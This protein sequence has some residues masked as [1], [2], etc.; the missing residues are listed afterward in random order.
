MEAD[1][2][3]PAAPYI[4]FGNGQLAF[5]I[6]NI[7]LLY[8]LWRNPFCKAGQISK[9]QHKPE[10]CKVMNILGINFDDLI[11]TAGNADKDMVVA[12]LN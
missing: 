9:L 1:I 5:L 11:A 12:K 8:K 10:F 3:V 7:E 6:E 2:A 4:F